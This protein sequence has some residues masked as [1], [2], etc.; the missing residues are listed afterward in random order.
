MVRMESA[1]AP[2]FNPGVNSSMVSV[3]IDFALSN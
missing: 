3:R 2:P 1:A